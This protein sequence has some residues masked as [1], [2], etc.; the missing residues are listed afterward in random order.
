MFQHVQNRDLK[1]YSYQP[2]LISLNQLH[3]Y[4]N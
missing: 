1:I 3:P 2:T 4:N